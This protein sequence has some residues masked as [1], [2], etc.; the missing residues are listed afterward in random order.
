MPPG[1]F[2]AGVRIFLGGDLVEGENSTTEP[3]MSEGKRE[4]G[5]DEG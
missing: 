3:A 2:G 4:K 1:L 5:K